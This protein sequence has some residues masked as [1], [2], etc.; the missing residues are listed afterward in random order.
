MTIFQSAVVHNLSTK[1]PRSDGNIPPSGGVTIHDSQHPLLSSPSLLLDL[2]FQ[3]IRWATSGCALK[4][5][6]RHFQLFPAQNNTFRPPQTL[7]T[8]KPNYQAHRAT[9]ENLH[10]LHQ[11]TSYLINLIPRIHIQLSFEIAP[12]CPLSSAQSITAYITSPQQYSYY[13]LILSLQPSM[14]FN[15]PQP[16]TVTDCARTAKETTT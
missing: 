11:R 14:P 12:L 6:I 9:G 3:D 8:P 1:L 7:S 13:N 15:R 4:H 16:H 2:P 10:E 5:M